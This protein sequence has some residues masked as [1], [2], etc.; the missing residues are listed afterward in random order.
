MREA[1]CICTSVAFTKSLEVVPKAAFSRSH[2]RFA[3]PSGGYGFEKS[4]LMRRSFTRVRRADSFETD[5]VGAGTLS[6]IRRSPWHIVGA[7]PSPIDAP[8]Q[9]RRSRSRS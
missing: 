7:S 5:A 4:E 8:V 2:Q 3:S 6:V 1:F 9:L